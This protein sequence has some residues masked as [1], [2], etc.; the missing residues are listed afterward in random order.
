MPN[1]ILDRLLAKAVLEAE[2]IAQPPMQML[3]VPASLF[4]RLL[5]GHHGT[6]VKNDDDECVSIRMRIAGRSILVRRLLRGEVVFFNNNGTH[7]YINL[8]ALRDK[9]RDDE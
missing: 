5:E 4:K 6:P 7:V 3:A 8:S 2:E 1:V 9:D